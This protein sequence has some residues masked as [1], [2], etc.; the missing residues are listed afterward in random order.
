MAWGPIAG[1]RPM[2]PGQRDPTG[3]APA[4]VPWRQ[5]LGWWEMADART[6]VETRARPGFAG[7]HRAH[8]QGRTSGHFPPSRLA[9][10]S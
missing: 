8:N 7:P 9:W 3:R 5:R 10:L 1:A 2:G 6:A 4:T